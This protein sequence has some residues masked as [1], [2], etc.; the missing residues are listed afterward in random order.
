M[1]RSKGGFGDFSK[2]R[3][4]QR[5]ALNELHISCEASLY[6]CLLQRGGPHIE[7]GA[8]SCSHVSLFHYST[9]VL[10]PRI[11]RAPIR[12][13]TLTGV[14]PPAVH[15]PLGLGVPLLRQQHQ[16]P[17]CSPATSSNSGSASHAHSTAPPG[18]TVCAFELRLSVSPSAIRTTRPLDQMRCCLSAPFSK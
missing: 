12:G 6:T 9:H 17:H 14:I 11:R 3:Y 15:L 5:N 7:N 16:P 13:S 10:A 2:S 8:V 18:S 1:T 4:T